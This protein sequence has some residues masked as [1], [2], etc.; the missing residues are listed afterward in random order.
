MLREIEEVTFNLYLQADDLVPR[1]GVVIRG[2]ISFLPEL[3]PGS[4]FSLS[5]RVDGFQVR[6]VGQHGHMKRVFGSEI[7]L[8]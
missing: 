3:L 7:Q 1:L 2:V 5:H 6:W 4:S 8:H